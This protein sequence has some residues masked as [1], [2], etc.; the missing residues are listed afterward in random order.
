MQCCPKSIKAKLHRIFF[1]Q[2]CLEPL[3]QHYIGFLP[4]QCCPKSIKETLHRI[5]TYTKLSGASPV[6]L[7][8]V[9]PCAMLSQQCQDNISQDFSL[10]KVVWSLL[11]NI[12]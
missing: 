6:K 10:Y 5:F 8:R 1:M 4:V 7:Q 3:R 2:C 9:F 12:A 11:D